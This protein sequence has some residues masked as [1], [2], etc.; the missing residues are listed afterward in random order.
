MK[1]NNHEDVPPKNPPNL[2]TQKGNDNLTQ[3][4]LFSDLS[5][6]ASNAQT[7]RTNSAPEEKQDEPVSDDYKSIKLSSE[8]A[9]ENKQT[10]ITILHDDNRSLGKILSETR[11]Q[12]D[13]T[14]E[15]VASETHIRGD[16]IQHL[17]ANN[18]EK[19]PSAT[20]YTKSYIKSLCRLYSLNSETLITKYEQRSLI[21]EPNGDSA[22]DT[23]SKPTPK[24]V[25]SENQNNPRSRK[26]FSITLGW[27]ISILISAVALITIIYLAIDRG[28]TGISRLNSSSAEQINSLIT[29]T[30]LEQFIIPEQLPLRELPI[31]EDSETQ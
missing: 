30:D 31:P 14:V 13:L 12:L 19:L 20:I 4:E 26:K 21:S 23:P 7:D 10:V 29:D 1:K 2:E 18:F 28:S 15:K 6:N 16:Y 22:T 8:S 3:P 9:M 5:F 24:V 27:A 17:E 25:P 11:K